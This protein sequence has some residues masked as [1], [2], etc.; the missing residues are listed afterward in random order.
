MI[1]SFLCRKLLHIDWRGLQDL[2]LQENSGDEDAVFVHASM[3]SWEKVELKM[4]VQSLL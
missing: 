4:A 1:T 2:H 3:V